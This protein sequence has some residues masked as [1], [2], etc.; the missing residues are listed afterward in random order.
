M[1]S[2]MTLVTCALAILTSAGL[3]GEDANWPVYMGN[4]SR[5]GISS[6]AV[7]T[8]ASPTW[9]FTM[10]KPIAGFKPFF[11]DVL[12]QQKGKTH[13]TSQFDFASAVVI[14]GTKAYFGSS[15]EERLFCVDVKTGKVLWVHQAEG[16]VRLSATIVDG[17]IYYGSDDGHVYCLDKDT[18][19]EKWDFTAS[20]TDRH[21]VANGRL[22]AQ[23]PVR[24]SITI[25]N[26]LAYFAAG[27]FPQSGGVHL[28][29]VDA[30]SGKQKWKTAMITSAQGYIMAEGN[31]LLVP[32]GRS[33]PV[34]FEIATGKRLT[35]LTGGIRRDGGGNTFVR[36]I[37]GLLVFGPNEKGCLWIRTD[38][39]NSNA[40]PKSTAI[41]GSL[42]VLEGL[43]LLSDGKQFYLLKDGTI[44]AMASEDFLKSIKLS[45]A[46]YSKR[47]GK[48]SKSIISGKGIIGRGD[49]IVA[50]DIEKYKKWTA[51]VPDAM[52]MIIAGDT[53]YAGGENI[54]YKINIADGSVTSLKVKGNAWE[55]SAGSG[56]LF[57]STDAGKVYC[58]GP[59]ASDLKIAS[60]SGNP[61]KVTPAMNSYAKAA[62]ARA[63]TKKGY[64]VI[65]GGV[66]GSLGY[67]LS[68]LTD[69]QIVYL[70]RD[71]KSA[72]TVRK[73][74]IDAGLYGHRI[75]VRMV[76][77]KNIPYLKYF[78]NLIVSE[79]GLNNADIGFGASEVYKILQPNGGALVLGGSAASLADSWA[80][81]MP[82]MKTSGAIAVVQRGDLIGA[83]NWTHMWGDARNTGC[84]DDDLVKGHEFDVQ[85]FGYPYPN[86][87]TT[88]WH[89]LSMGALYNK[90][91]LLT[92]YTDYVIAVDAW[93]GT[94]LWERG[95][96]GSIRYS[97]GREG[98]HSCM[99]E[100][101]FYL[102]FDSECHVIDL[103]DGKTVRKITLP[104]AGDWGYIASHGP[105]LIGST[106]DPKA[107]SKAAS[108]DDGKA[109][110]YIGYSNK[111]GEIKATFVT[112]DTLSVTDKKTG[113]VIWTYTNP[114][115][116]IINSTITVADEKIFFAEVALPTGS[117][118]LPDI[119]AKKPQLVALKLS[120]KT[121]AWAAKQ[122]FTPNMQDVLYMS[123]S[124][125]FLYV[126]SSTHSPKGITYHFQKIDAENGTTKWSSKTPYKKSLFSHN[127]VVGHPILFDD[128]LWSIPPGGNPAKISIVDGSYKYL[129]K[130]R[131]KCCAM[132]MAS[133]H[134]AVFRNGTIH[135]V[136]LDSQDQGLLTHVN[137]PSCWMSTIPAGGVL[138]MPEGSLGCVCDYPYQGSIVLAPKE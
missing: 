19:E 43:R 119:S 118:Y 92:L 22:A 1:Y 63:D 97:P 70:M 68:G 27:L 51:A 93:N 133:K 105:Y 110:W 29:S 86:G 95:I 131:N 111:K 115:H 41:A 83:G 48:G 112:S 126:S 53:I 55:L 21:I 32:T 44:K 64:C 108:K 109:L 130:G 77:G 136:D 75:T 135:Y 134:I 117:Y 49:R 103:K 13:A 132:A 36:M 122:A 18:G 40:K 58:F 2:K 46:E 26:G 42:T 23:C 74:I 28:Y 129:P 72:D 54:V 107:T 82:E 76:D 38:T 57:V 100:N 73:A 3:A 39:D 128:T 14:H 11:G 78:A 79:T 80:S 33:A 10:S 102:T 71:N 52:H 56:S 20:P 138:M 69:M 12:G 88:G 35:Y 16:S 123:Y 125:G 114:G 5:N 34:E 31:K 65:L 89:Y 9:T 87:H 121:Q 62:E 37:N 7:T 94:V 30:I 137:R 98:G 4:S 104:N 66:D 99:D 67:A 96:K 50:G 124:N 6:Q 25:D 47:H 17:L 127:A 116:S 8:K 61:I 113:K 84:S 101:Y 106:Q 90:G 85:W 91:I 60:Q 24:T 45:A 15:T 81:D 120:D 59:V